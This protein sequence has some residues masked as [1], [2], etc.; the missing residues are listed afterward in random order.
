MQ[1]EIEQMMKIVVMRYCEKMNL[2]SVPDDELSFTS[3]KE[4]ELTTISQVE[5]IHESSM[6]EMV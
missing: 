2:L 3:R 4:L 5:S 1:I 6:N